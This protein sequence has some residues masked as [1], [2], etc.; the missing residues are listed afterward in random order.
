MQEF[1]T[2]GEDPSVFSNL[3]RLISDDTD[4]LAAAAAGGIAGVAFLATMAV[5]LK[6]SGR[7]LDDL[8]LLGSTFTKNPD[9]ARK[10]GLAIHAV[11]SVGLGTL[12]AAVAHDRMPGPPAV[13]GAV[14][15]N[16]ENTLIYP[17][18]A[19]DKFHPAVKDGRLDSYWSVKSYLW[20]VPRHTVYGLVLGGLYEAWRSK[21][22]TA[23][24]EESST[25]PEPLNS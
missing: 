10:V 22:V 16:V 23:G 3:R 4:Y 12:Y 6:L 14:F 7:K 15:A 21:P 24:I 8:I 11:N 9:N 25:I 2:T 17:L 1:S 13:R 20:T 18:T 19:L 5:E